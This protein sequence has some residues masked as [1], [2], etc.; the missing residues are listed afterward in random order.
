MYTHSTLNF[1]KVY[2]SHF[3][4]IFVNLCFGYLA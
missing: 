4:Y 1:S 2:H 3:K